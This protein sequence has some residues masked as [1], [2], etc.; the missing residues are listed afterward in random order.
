LNPEVSGNLSTRP[1]R[2]FVL[3]PIDGVIEGEGLFFT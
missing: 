3:S 2:V 1:K